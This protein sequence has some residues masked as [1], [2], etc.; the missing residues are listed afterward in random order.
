MNGSERVHRALDS[1]VEFVERKLHVRSKLRRRRRLAGRSLPDGDE[2][3]SRF[4]ARG[5]G[6][7][8]A[9]NFPSL[10]PVEE[11]SGEEERAPDHEG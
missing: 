6:D 11:S 2:A 5:K 8:R 7:V 1:S 4:A 10:S 9:V 3:L